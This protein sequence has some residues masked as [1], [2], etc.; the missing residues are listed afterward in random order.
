MSRSCRNVLKQHETLRLTWVLSMDRSESV[1]TPK[2]RADEEGSME[3]EPI[4]GP[5]VRKRCWRRVVVHDRNLV[6]SLF[7]CRRLECIHSATALRH[8]LTFDKKTSTFAGEQAPCIYLGV[9]SV[10]VR[11]QAEF[12]NECHVVGGV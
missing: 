2:S 12:E 6:L 8:S 9:I 10:E 5:V 3:E 7:S 4:I 11:R 1:K